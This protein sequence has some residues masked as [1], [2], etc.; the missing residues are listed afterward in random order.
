MSTRNKILFK[1]FDESGNGVKDSVVNSIDDQHVVVEVVGRP[2]R[3][4]LTAT[5]SSQVV[6]KIGI[7]RTIP[8]NIIVFYL[9]DTLL[10]RKSI[11]IWI[12][13][14][15]IEIRYYGDYPIQ[16]IKT[17][18]KKCV[19]VPESEYKLYT[20][21]FSND[22]RFDQQGLLYLL[23]KPMLFGQL[24]NYNIDNHEILRH[25]TTNSILKYQYCSYLDFSEKIYDGF[26]D[27]GTL[28]DG[29][30]R[31]T[32]LANFLPG[33]EIYDR[34]RRNVIVVDT[35]EDVRLKGFIE[36]MKSNHNFVK[37]YSDPNEILYTKF[38]EVVLSCINEFILEPV[39]GDVVTHHEPLSNNKENLGNVKNGVCRHKAIL[40][41]FVI[42][43]LCDANIECSLD[44]GQS[45]GDKHVW[46]TIIIHSRGK[47]EMW[48]VDPRNRP[49]LL[50]ESEFKFM[51]PGHM[52]RLATPHGMVP[53]TGVRR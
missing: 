26:F 20:T 42:D 38:V 29:V 28:D 16:G 6:M 36:T 40:F 31:S 14:P 11:K 47:N 7:N 8:P 35:R 33:G 25:P 51:F 13:C 4:L 2:K 46:N 30:R 19:D 24:K 12:I 1:S 22:Y 41:K 15:S 17:E 3:Y 53:S 27:V 45:D 5:K 18:W 37:Q 48:L 39:S 32:T 9:C 34:M 10:V 49:T 44:R 43:S 50:T 52:A 21:C 23:Q